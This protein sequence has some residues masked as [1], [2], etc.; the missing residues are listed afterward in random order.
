MKTEVYVF[1]A[2]KEKEILYHK[3]LW[4]IRNTS[5]LSM[6]APCD[7]K[8][9]IQ[10]VT[11]EEFESDVKNSFQEIMDMITR[12]REIEEAIHKANAEIII[13]TCLGEMTISDAYKLHNEIGRMSYDE[14]FRRFKR[15]LYGLIEIAYTTNTIEI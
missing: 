4:Q 9:D 14:K 7:A 10:N 1:H 6:M 11:K 13:E 3:I 2:I 15:E 12:Y 5:F 8:V